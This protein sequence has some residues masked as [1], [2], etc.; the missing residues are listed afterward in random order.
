MAGASANPF[1]QFDAG[2]SQ[3]APASAAP[4]AAANPFDQ[5]DAPANNDNAYQGTSVPYGAASVASGFNRG[6]A[7]TV[8][9][10]VDLATWGMKK[11]GLYRSDPN[12]PPPVMGSEWIAK[13]IMPAPLPAHNETE[14]ALQ[15]VGAGVAGAVLPIGGAAA[16]GEKAA[17]AAAPYVGEATNA[18]IATA[19]GVGGL[20]GGSGQLAADAVPDKFKPLAA[21]IGG[22]AVPAAAIGVPALAVVGGRA[23]INAMPA[24]TEAGKTAAARAQV[25]RELTS[26]AADAPA[27]TSTLA[28]APREIIP[29]SVGTARPDV[30]RYWTYRL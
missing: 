29:G 27:A 22:I 7:E 1:D 9:G 14:R 8:G 20:S 28:T 19:A 21:T 30:R 18:G 10:P 26:A 15:G 4:S 2:P 16:L 3:G 17:L 11:A 13:H 5:F 25:G 23:A 6:V 24:I 12:A